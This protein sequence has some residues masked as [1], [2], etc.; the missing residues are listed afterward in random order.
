MLA[1][2]KRAIELASIYVQLHPELI[3]EPPLN[4]DD[5]AEPKV[6]GGVGKP[7]RSRRKPSAK[8][9]WDNVNGFDES[10]E[11]IDRF[12]EVLYCEFEHRIQMHQLLVDKDEYYRGKPDV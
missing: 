8:K 5:E 7:K 12:G 9:T 11:A 1:N 6:K 10:Q 3:G 2:K 4:D